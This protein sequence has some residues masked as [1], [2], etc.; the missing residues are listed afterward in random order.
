VGRAG[1]RPACLILARTAR[2]RFEPLTCGTH[3]SAAAI[4]LSFFLPTSVFF[5]PFSNRIESDR[6]QSL[7]SIDS[8]FPS[9]KTEPP[10]PSAPHPTQS[11]SKNHLGLLRRELRLHRRCSELTTAF[12]S[13]P[14]PL[15]T[16][17]KFTV[18][19]ATSRCSSSIE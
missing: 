10:H 6:S 18:F 11:R 7:L 15:F 9:Y 5:F 1:Q 2:F 16:R 12:R 8:G 4:S 14:G 13:F 17:G 19:R 3:W